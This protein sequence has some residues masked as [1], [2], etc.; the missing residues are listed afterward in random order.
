M[1]LNIGENIKKLRV[2]KGAT[3]EQLAENLSITY[4]SVSKWENNL[5]SPDLYLIPVIA[6]YF[7][8][9]IDELFQPNIKG[10]KHKAARLGA[11][12]NFRRTKENFDKAEAEYEKLIVEN[13]IDAKDIGDYGNLVQ[14]RAQDL[15]K[16]AEELLKQSINMG[17]EQS[18][19]QLIGFLASQGR[20]NENIKMYEEAVKDNSERERNWYLLAY[21]YGGNYGDGIN[22]EKALEVCKK[23]LEKF[24]DEAGLLSLCGDLYRGLKR[25]DESFYYYMKSIEQNTDMGDNY[26]GLAFAYSEAKKYNEAIWAWQEV[27]ALHGRLGMTAEEV[28]MSKEWPKKEIAKLQSIINNKYVE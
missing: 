14:S 11:L 17:N 23:G 15:N 6:E 8:V 1:V 21:S 7:G 12:Y 4:Q 5:T 9:S 13:K 10:Y 3:Q 19:S 25:Y 2:E 22:P 26:Y 16:R 28:E 24:P 18:E 27:I 20:Q